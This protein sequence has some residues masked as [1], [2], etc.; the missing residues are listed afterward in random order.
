MTQ[1]VCAL[2][3]T[4]GPEV[5]TP[6]SG[7][8]QNEAMCWSVPSASLIGIQTVMMLSSGTVTVVSGT[9]GGSF[10]GEIVI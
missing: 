8:S 2:L 7:A 1:T 9:T 5:I 10:T 3:S 4:I 6:L